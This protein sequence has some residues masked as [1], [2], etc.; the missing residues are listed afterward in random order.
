M[1]K[2]QLPPNAAFVGATEIKATELRTFTRNLLERAKFQ[3]ERFVVCTYGQPMAVL[4]G[5]DEYCRL[6]EQ[7]S[8]EA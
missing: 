7:F 1:S 8:E 5:I 4:I 3:G 2:E 6:V